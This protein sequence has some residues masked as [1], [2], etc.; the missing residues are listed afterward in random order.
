MEK[1]G[2]FKKYWLV[3]LCGLL[4]GGA[5]VL[6]SAHGNPANMGFCIACFLRDIAGSLKLHQAGVVQYFR[7]EIV[8]IV[9]GACLMALIGKEF[10]PKAGSSPVIRSPCAIHRSR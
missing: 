1:Q 2:F 6:L 8:G 9:V 4:I 5:A 7:P 10:K 3:L